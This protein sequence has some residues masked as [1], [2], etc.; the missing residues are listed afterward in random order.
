MK[1]K[2]KAD[3]ATKDT[4]REM[5]RRLALGILPPRFC[6]YTDKDGTI[7]FGVICHVLRASSE[8]DRSKV[9]DC[10]REL[11]EEGYFTYPKDWVNETG[12]EDGQE[13]SYSYPLQL[14]VR[15]E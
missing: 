7:E 5:L 15:S 2:M 6:K 11:F 1:R 14:I 13:I 3:P 4:V 8:A 10:V 12:E 9:A